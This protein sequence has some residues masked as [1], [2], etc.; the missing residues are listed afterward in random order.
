M[1]R[2]SRTVR[3]RTRW[4]V[5]LALAAALAPTAACA[6]AAIDLYYERALMVAADARCSLFSPQIATALAAATAQARGAA[7]RAGADEESLERVRYRARGRAAGEACNSPDLVQAAARVREAFQGYARLNRIDYP[8]EV[9]DW[10]ATRVTPAEGLASWS[11]VQGARIGPDQLT[12][13]LASRGAFRPLM[14]VAHFSDGA[15]PYAA[16]LVMRDVSRAPRPYLDRSRADRQG[17]LPLA[18]RSPPRAAS[19]IFAAEARSVAGADLAGEQRGGWAFRFPVAADRALAALD[20]R[21]A[22]AI[23]FVFTGEQGDVV[24]TAFIEVGDYAAGR[25]FLNVPAAR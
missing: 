21:E 8:G 23:E 14:A 7:L 9:A 24:R 11:L 18:A 12:F 16:R 19:R 17:R 6:S 2:L 25:A 1:E 3:V 15:R 4:A 20:P 13:G 22:I 5:G 10:R